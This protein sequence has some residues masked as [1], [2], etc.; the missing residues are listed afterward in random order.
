MVGEEILHWSGLRVRGAEIAVDL[1]DDEVRQQLIATVR[2]LEAT[3][4][5]EWAALGVK[6]LRPNENTY[7]FRLPPKYV[8]FVSWHGRGLVEVNDLLTEEALRF[9]GGHDRR[10]EVAAS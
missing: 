3:E 1:I 9:W 10:S 7:Y 5:S 4:P 2:K 6:R 8:V